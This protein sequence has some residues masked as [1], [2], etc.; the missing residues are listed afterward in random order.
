M[1]EILNNTFKDYQ[2][3]ENGHSYIHKPTGQSLISV[4][5]LLK[6]LCPKFNESF[7]TPYKVLQR[8]GYDVKY[9][10]DNNVS[11]IVNGKRFN[12]NF[13]SLD[14]FDLE[15]S[16]QDLKN[17]WALAAKIGN[18]RGTLLHTFMENLWNRKILID[19][20]P[21]VINSLSAVE[22]IKYIKSIEILKQLGLD[23]YQSLLETYTLVTTEFVVGDIDYKLAG[24]FDLLLYNRK[25]NRYEI[26]DYKTDKKMRD[27]SRELI[28][29]FKIP[30]SEINKYSLQLGIYKHII[31]KNTD[32]EIDKC[33][34]AH[35]NYKK[36]TTEIIETNN[37]SE[38]IKEYFNGN[39]KSTHF[40]YQRID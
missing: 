40:E 38:I 27:N 19:D 3:I 11:F 23:L 36:N 39:N 30:Y 13:D 37:Y 1:I 18:T 12:P 22:A 6:K 29:S 14:Q 15:F 2:F 7:W 5:T 28:K 24:T 25:T 20:V 32:I 9:E 26:W 34:I 35:F 10:F 33:Y 16:E 31:E 8:N 21:T 17:E 4:T